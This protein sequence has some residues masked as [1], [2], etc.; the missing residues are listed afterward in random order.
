MIDPKHNYLL[1]RE[2]FWHEG[3]AGEHE[4]ADAAFHYADGEEPMRV[5]LVVREV[6]LSEWERCPNCGAAVE[7]GI[8]CWASLDCV[9]KRNTTTGPPC[10]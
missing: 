7:K 6:D 10:G 3:Y 8:W 9:A 1:V 4:A 2:D 5:L